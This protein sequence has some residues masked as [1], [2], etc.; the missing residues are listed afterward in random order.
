MSADRDVERLLDAWFADGPMQVSD[1][2]FDEAVGRVHRQRQR[3]AWRFLWKEPRMSSWFK[4][5]VAVA[6]VVVVFVAGFAMLGGS[7]GVIGGVATPSAS[8]SPTPLLTPVA[9]T[10]PPPT[11]RVLPEGELPG[12]T[13]RLNAFPG[14]PMAIQVDV[15]AG[16]SGVPPWALIGPGSAGTEAPTGSG[17]AFI[18]GD[19]IHGDPCHWDTAGTGDVTQP[20]S[21]DVGPT[22]DDLVNALRANTAY[23][24]T[25]PVPVTI[26]GYAGKQL[27]LQLP[28]DVDFAATCDKE[29][30]DPDGHYLPFSGLNAGLYAQGQGNRWTV[31][32]VD[33]GGT[34][35]I[36]VVLDYVGTSAADQA[37]ARAIIDSLVITP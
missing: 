19:G 10:Q 13:Y 8:P 5:A 24:T 32:I 22:V 16:W 11:T 18:G 7:G 12:G 3:P 23:T 29:T 36:V 15:P 37:A 25:A 26:G 2:V 14:E 1:H 4:A 31:S 21:V 20:G 33:V 17:I 9:T 34:R 30:G 28:S 35:L 27:V 6:A